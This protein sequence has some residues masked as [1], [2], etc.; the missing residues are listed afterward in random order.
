MK[1][2]QSEAKF[3]A[4]MKLAEILQIV[5]FLD[6]KSQCKNSITA[7]KKPNFSN[8]KKMFLHCDPLIIETFGS[9][10]ALRNKFLVVLL[11]TQGVHEKKTLLTLI[12][13]GTIVLVFLVLII[14][15]Q[16]HIFFSLA[17]FSDKKKSN[18]WKYKN[19]SI[20]YI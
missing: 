13:L 9:V 4:Y 14:K 2:E 6:T 3:F 11:I 5:K 12:I 17:P 1:I 20:L 18:I 8:A 15:N 10:E 19:L 7:L 16:L